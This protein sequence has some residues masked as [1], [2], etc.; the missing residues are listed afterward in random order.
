MIRIKYAIP[1][2]KYSAM[3]KYDDIALFELAQNV[4]FNQF[5]RPACVN[6]NIN[7]TWQNALASGYG[8]LSF[9]M[10][11]HTLDLLLLFRDATCSC[12]E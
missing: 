5:I 3:S 2:P 7:V 6:T 1:H 12:F 4:Q 10:T 9:G 8:Q 11:L